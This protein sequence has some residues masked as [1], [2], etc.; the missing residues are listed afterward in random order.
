[1][2]EKLFV[3]H[4]SKVRGW[5]FQDWLLIESMASTSS[6]FC[7]VGT[8][9]LELDSEAQRDVIDGKLK[10]SFK[11]RV[12][13]RKL[14]RCLRDDVISWSCEELYFLIHCFYLPTPASGV[15][16]SSSKHVRVSRVVWPQPF[17]ISTPTA[18]APKLSFQRARSFRA[19]CL[20]ST[21]EF[22]VVLIELSWETWRKLLFT[23]LQFQV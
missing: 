1:M 4:T 12:L 10:L 8:P 6:C 7:E 14:W 16:E 13:L 23:F 21:R 2:G 15:T 19:S 17:I 3:D 9:Q 11:L 18:L 22:T 5:K 20:Q